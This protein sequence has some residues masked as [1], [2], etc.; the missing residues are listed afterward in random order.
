MKSSKVWWLGAGAAAAAVV[1]WRIAS[2]SS[3]DTPKAPEPL[4]AQ[5]AIVLSTTKQ[6]TKHADDV[7][8]NSGDSVTHTLEPLPPIEAVESDDRKVGSAL[9]PAVFLHFGERPRSA[10]VAAYTKMWKKHSGAWD[11]L[12]LDARGYRPVL[13]KP[14][15]PDP[16]EKV[17]RLACTID[18]VQTMRLKE[19]EKVAVRKLSSGCVDLAIR[20]HA[21][22]ESGTISSE[23]VSKTIDKLARLRDG[24]GASV[25]VQLVSDSKPFRAV[26]VHRV[27]RALGF[28][29]SDFGSYAWYNPTDIGHDVVLT[30]RP[31]EAPNQFDFEKSSGSYEG[32]SSA[33]TSIRCLFRS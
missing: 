30:M 6:A 8:G 14:K 2:S 5:P 1:I 17:E 20:L 24:A 16:S 25:D 27:A 22:T 23:T 31:T 13:D 12:V 11:V 29:R 7:M 33:S 4:T 15:K 26:D 18:I 19:D 9:R 28:E 21:K 10:V 3:T 32:I